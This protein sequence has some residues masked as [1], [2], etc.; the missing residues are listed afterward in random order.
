MLP[1]LVP[2][3]RAILI[4]L[5]TQIAAKTF[6]LQCVIVDCT[7]STTLEDFAAALLLPP[8]P[9]SRSI[10]PNSSRT[11][12]YFHIKP[13]SYSRGSIPVS[14]PTSSQIANFVLAKNLDRAPQ[15]VQIQALELLRTHR[16]FTRTSVQ[17]APKQFIFLPVLGA[18]SG[19]KAR[20]TD[21]LND[22]FFIAHFH[23][24]QDGY[25][26]LE[27]AEGGVA[28]DDSASTESVVKKAH[29]VETSTETL[30]SETVG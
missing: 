15:A 2:S 26:N 10:S 12:S 29:G 28:D 1:S 16:I 20:V 21:H 18:S 27:E 8:P 11:E 22:F 4:R 23:D 30:I 13:L 7:A 9:T 6:G 5:V 24:P 17:A 25:V 14:T 3:L 19:G